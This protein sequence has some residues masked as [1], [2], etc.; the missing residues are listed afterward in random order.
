MYSYCSWITACLKCKSHSV[1]MHCGNYNLDQKSFTNFWWSLDCQK[2]NRSRRS[3]L[4]QL[5]WQCLC[6][7]CNHWDFKSPLILWKQIDTKNTVRAISPN[8]YS[9]AETWFF[10]QILFGRQRMSQNLSLSCKALKQG[11]Y[12]SCL[13][14]K[15]GDFRLFRLKPN[16]FSTL[17][18]Q[19]QILDLCQSPWSAISFS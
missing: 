16:N 10:W 19:K 18:L 2:S 5:Q 13:W 7:V 14:K 17:R 3:S 9:L 12:S 15:L 4:N 6:L 1:W 11:V 8:I